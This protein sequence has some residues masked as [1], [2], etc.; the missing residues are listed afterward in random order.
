MA[1]AGDY[2]PTIT[3][4]CERML[5]TVIG[6]AGFWGRRLYLV[7][8][9]VPRYLY[10]RASD[11]APAHVGS[12][13]VDLAV[14]LMVD[15]PTSKS[16]ETL[17]RNLLDAG[18][19]QAPLVDDPDFRWRKEA[20]GV[21]LILEFICDTDKVEPGVSFKPRSGSGS[22]FQAFNVH[23]A[24]LVSLDY[25]LV[26]IA[27]ERLDGGGVATARVRVAGLLPF[28]ILKISAFF[29]RHHDK[30]AYD[31][32]WIL[33]NHPDGPEGSGREMAVSQVVAD[34]LAA[35]ALALLR[36]R[37]SEARND[38]PTAYAAF[39]EVTGDP[40]ARAR[41]RNEA[42]ETVRIALRAFDGARETAE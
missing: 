42:V 36:D 20:D 8:G 21:S 7:G 23:G 30:D 34:P 31:I 32:I 2:D 24:H 39:L 38:A 35:E 27:A 9:L 41:L 13:D 15:D 5:V 1:S 22:R 14:I 6:N 33:A 4:L 40:E 29:D 17:A 25:K 11:E 16:Y 26:E 28:V 12:R 19:R 3:D 18:F 37:F 10:G